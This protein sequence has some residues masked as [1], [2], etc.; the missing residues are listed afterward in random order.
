MHEKTSPKP[1][2]NTN[3]A[4]HAALRER[5]DAHFQRTGRPKRGNWQIYVKAAILLSFFFFSYTALVF[6]AAN[7]WQG[8]ILATMLAFS[9]IGIGFN[10]V[11]DGGHRG[12]SERQWVNRLA[13][14]TSDLIGAS[15]YVWHWKHARFHH[16]FVNITGHDP[17][18]DLGIF[19]RFSPHQRR[20]WFH[21]WQHLYMWVLYAFLAMKF[22]LYSDFHH[23]FFGRIHTHRMPRPKGWNLL[24]F[25]GGKSIFFALAFVLPLFY[26]PVSVVV[27]YYLVTVLMM[28]IPLAVVFQLPHCTGRSE[29]PLPDKVSREMKNPW[30]VHQAE[31][32]LDYDRHSRIKT[33]LLGGLNFHLEHHLFPSICHIN[34]PGMSKVV[35]ET[36][37]EF[38]VK[39]AEHRTLWVGLAEHYRWLREMG[40]PG[41]LDA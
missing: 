13:A 15:S 37:R 29:F 10:I 18:V 24:V 9:M 33:W 40:R 6:L 35:E 16:N 28:G 27:F 12:F 7:L 32:T 14:L 20:L 41:P 19:A 30:A 8:T 34:Y 23:L 39:Y 3:L 5:I 31:V 25:I 11:H 4:F 26:H 36:C 21:R 2:F 17:D 1:K 38:S 22:H